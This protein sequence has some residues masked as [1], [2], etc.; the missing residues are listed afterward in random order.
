MN[1]IPKGSTVGFYR[2]KVK[3]GPFNM[4]SPLDM[5]APVTI[6]VEKEFVVRK[7][8]NS[9]ERGNVIV[10]VKKK[11]MF[12]SYGSYRVLHYKD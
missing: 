1:K 8:I 3:N 10:R 11:Q 6:Q 12:L 5:N 2:S 7:V 9:D 4:Y